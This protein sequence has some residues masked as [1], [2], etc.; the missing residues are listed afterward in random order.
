[1]PILVRLTVAAAL[2]ALPL[3]RTAA[4]PPRPIVPADLLRLR[5]VGNP[6]VSPDGE[7]VAFTVS[8]V[9]S[10]K[11]RR[12][13]DVHMVRWDGSRSLRLTT[14][15]ESESQPRWSPDGRYLSFVSS[16]QG[17]E[18]AQLWLLER[19][20]GEAQRVTELD[21]GVDDY[22]WSPDGSR[23]VI[24][25]KDTDS[26]AKADTTRPRP[27][28]I[29]R[30][31]IKRDGDGWLDRRR[32]HLYLFDVASR[33]ITP[34]TRG[35][36]DDREPAWAP[37]GRRIVFT[38][39]RHTDEDRSDETDLYIVDARA[40]AEPERLTSSAAYERSA[41]FSPDGRWIAFIQGTFT[42]VPMYG[43]PRIAV[44]PATG[45]PPRV[46]APSLDRPQAEPVWTADGNAVLTV[47]E[48]DRQTPL[49]RI[50]V[51]DG[52]VTRL[53][54]GR[55]AVEA[56]HQTA[57]RIAL[58]VS[59]FNTP[60][61]LYALEGDS[62]RRLTRENEAWRA[63]VRIAEAEEFTARS[64]DGTMVH[65]ILTRALDRDASRPQRTVLWIHGG[66]VAQDDWG[67]WLEKE[68]L[69]AA[70][71]NVLQMNYRGSSGRGEAYQRAIYADWCG[72]EV[73]DLMASVDEAVRRGIADSARLGV[74]GWS[75]GGILTDCLIATTSRFRAAISGAGSSLF[76]SMYGS[77]QYPAQYDTELG[78]PWK[79]P[80]LWEKVSYAFWRAERIKTPTLF[81]G[82][83]DDFNVPIAG[84]EQMYLALRTQNIP[85][86]LVVYPGENHGIRRPSFAVDR[87]SRWTEWLE[88]HTPASR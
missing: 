20:G 21:E 43:T 10:T 61:E 38:S 50:A 72:K 5:T 60:S 58:R 53:I 27:L 16:R 46:L 19:A 79:N 12:D 85:T 3:A 29:D 13:T 37:D 69:A 36:H 11:D 40:G 49:V 74:G 17:S 15:S 57:G 63:G 45:G 26:L 6:Q 80:R 86:Q 55:R 64:R 83:A 75:Y 9:D 41:A 51:V 32:T 47:L 76:T 25:S 52:A 35:D 30:Y 23:I 70:G 39:A 62:L 34:L 28:V 22:A 1:M 33:A 82:G 2:A 71:W 24:V 31:L 56:V 73:E 87:L 65:G 68:A 88:R 67:F 7:W 81:M 48:D 54:D 44:M 77:D 42:P 84:S 14:S 66:P 59:D 78:A 8:R 18:S 4:Q